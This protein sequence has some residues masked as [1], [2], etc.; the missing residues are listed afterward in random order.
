MKKKEIYELQN[1]LKISK[2]KWNKKLLRPLMDA[3]EIPCSY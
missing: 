1:E 2:Q 3:L